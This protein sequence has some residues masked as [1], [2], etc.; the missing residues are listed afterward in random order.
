MIFDPSCRRNA[1]KNILL[2]GVG[3]TAFSS[4]NVAANN[5]YQEHHAKHQALAPVAEL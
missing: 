1:I 3:V 2:A 4:F 5:Y